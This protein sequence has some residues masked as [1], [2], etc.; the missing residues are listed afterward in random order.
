MDICKIEKLL[1]FHKKSLIQNTNKSYPETADN[2]SHNNSK[3]MVISKITFDDPNQNRTCREKKFIVVGYE[4]GFNKIQMDNMLQLDNSEDREGKISSE[5]VGI[6]YFITPYSKFI[7]MINLDKNIEDEAKFIMKKYKYRKFID[8]LQREQMKDIEKRK[9][10]QWTDSAYL[11]IP[12]IDNENE[13]V[14]IM[15]KKLK[16]IYRQFRSKYKG[17]I[18]LELQKKEHSDEYN[19]EEMNKCFSEKFYHKIKNENVEIRLNEINAKYQYDNDDSKIVLTKYIYDKIVK[20]K[21]IINY[22][23]AILKSKKMKFVISEFGKG[24]SIYMVLDETVLH[25]VNKHDGNDGWKKKGGQKGGISNILN[26]L[27]KNKAFELEILRFDNKINN[28]KEIITLYNG[29]VDKNIILNTESLKKIKLNN[30]ENLKLIFTIF[31]K[32]TPYYTFND[33]KSKTSLF[34]NDKLKKSIVEIINIVTE[35]LDFNIENDEVFN[36]K[37]A[38]LFNKIDDFKKIDKKDKKN[39]KIQKKNKNK[40]NNFSKAAINKA[41]KKL[42]GKDN[43]IG[44]KFDDVYRRCEIDHKDGNNENN[45]KENCNYLPVELHSIKSCDKDL[46]NKLLV[47]PYERNELR[48]YY[49]ENYLDSFNFENDKK[50]LTEEQNKKLISIK[51]KIEH[52]LC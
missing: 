44:C 28:N 42:D 14:E 3:K 39:K 52:F 30:D 18:I 6:K 36:E 38:E 22:K 46:Y 2:M 7:T 32:K 33:T 35:N 45:S 8:A 47:S 15:D 5:G 12:E 23:K 1:K 17:F 16:F 43:L 49:L 20:P 13:L 10:I 19:L 37:L 4:N 51:E 21:D 9:D 26:N 34:N 40:R 48:L 50:D 25:F 31:K 29:S 11:T 24:H 41:K 27:E